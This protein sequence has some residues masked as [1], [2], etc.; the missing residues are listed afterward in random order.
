MLQTAQ[1]SEGGKPPATENSD[2]SGV[3]AEIRLFWRTEGSRIFA[4]AFFVTLSAVLLLMVLCYIHHL[5]FPFRPVMM[6]GGHLH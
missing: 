1:T 2:P 5:C 4:T 6:M 3:T